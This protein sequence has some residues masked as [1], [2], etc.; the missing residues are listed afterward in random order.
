MRGG[1][2]E[3]SFASCTMCFLSLSLCSIFLGVIAQH[4]PFPPRIKN[5]LSGPTTFYVMKEF[6]YICITRVVVVVVV[7][8]ITERIISGDNFRK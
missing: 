5:L 2:G 3:G 8:Y 7:F 4:S 6:G 1:G